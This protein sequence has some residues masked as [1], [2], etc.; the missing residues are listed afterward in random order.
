MGLA[1]SGNSATDGVDQTRMKLDNYEKTRA[2]TQTKYKNTPCG[3]KDN[4][5]AKHTRMK[6]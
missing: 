2:N 5:R 3:R 1:V 4:V 6:L